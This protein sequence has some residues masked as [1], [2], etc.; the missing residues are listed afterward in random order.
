M[1]VRSIMI[2][3]FIISVLSIPYIEKGIALYVQQSLL[4]KTLATITAYIIYQYVLP[5]I[6]LPIFE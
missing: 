4:V 1:K 5:R 6:I 2:V 3:S